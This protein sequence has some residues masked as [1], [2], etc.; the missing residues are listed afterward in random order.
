MLALDPICTWCNGNRHRVSRMD[1]VGIY[2]D[3]WWLEI[4]NVRR[5]WQTFM[6]RVYACL[7]VMTAYHWKGIQ[8]RPVSSHT[9]I[10][11]PNE[12]IRRYEIAK[13]CTT[14]KERAWQTPITKVQMSRGMFLC[15]AQQYVANTACEL[16][17]SECL[18]YAGRDTLCVRNGRFLRRFFSPYPEIETKHRVAKR[19]YHVDVWVCVCVCVWLGFHYSGSLLPVR[20]MYCCRGQQG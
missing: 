1:V 10:T 15:V 5:C 14:N 19:V 2:C 16:E 13:Q 9:P 6:I 20:A 8:S 18:C 11:G 7:S 17:G 3:V 4:V 12:Y